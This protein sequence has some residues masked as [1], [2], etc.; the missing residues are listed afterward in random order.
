MAKKHRCVGAFLLLWLLAVPGLAVPAAGA[1]L[2]GAMPA[3]E[4]N[5]WGT[6]GRMFTAQTPLMGP[7]FAEFAETLTGMG[8]TPS[9]RQ[10]GTFY[11]FRLKPGAIFRWSLS[12]TLYFPLPP[13]RPKPLVAKKEKGKIALIIDDFGPDLP[14]AKELLSLPF[15]F[16]AAVMPGYAQT[17]AIAELAKKQ[18]KGLI[19]HLPMEPVG[20]QNPGAGAIWV[21]MD[22]SAIKE[23]V[24]KDLAEIPGASGLNNHMGSRAATDRRVMGAVLSVAKEKGLFFVD[25]ATIAGSVIPEV[26]RELKVPWGRNQVFLDN[27]AD[28]KKIRERIRFAARLAEKNGSVIAIG[29]V[30]PATIKAL[31][32]IWREM[33]DQGFRWVLLPEVI[34]RP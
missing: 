22:D 31:A 20:Q 3:I 6:R 27:E 10:T 13:P 16:T 18:G 1:A 30:R 23:Q 19:L 34:N 32:G 24:V 28:V 17:T 21:K 9:I 14:L 26:A 8:F 15:P 29:H 5:W 33:E 12:S 4:Q 2:P 25:S 11:V 7:V